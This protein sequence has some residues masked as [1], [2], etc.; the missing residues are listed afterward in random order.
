VRLRSCFAIFSLSLTLLSVSA[1]AAHACVGAQ[2]LQIWSTAPGGGALTLEWDFEVKVQTFESFCTPDRATC[3]YSTIDPGFQAPVDDVAGDSFYRLGDATSVRVELIATAP[4]LTVAINGQ[5]LEDAGDTVNLGTMPDVHVHPSWQILVPGD[6]RGDFDFS[7][8]LITDSP[9][10]QDSDVITVV[11]TNHQ[12]APEPTPTRTPEPSCAGDCNRDEQV[13]VDEILTGVSIA[14]GSISLAECEAFDGNGDEQVSVDELIG[15]IDASLIGCFA[16][17]PVTL[18][19]IQET[20]FTPSCAIETCHNSDSAT[21]N[22]IL[23]AELAR[24]QLISVL[25]DAAPARAAGLLRVAPGNLERSFLYSKLI[26]PRPGHG[27][28]MPLNAPPLPAAQIK[29]VGDWILTGAE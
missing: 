10:Y 26:G 11:V 29:Q 16:V 4:G 7:F 22:L 2:C 13:T 12:P 23:T 28:R 9:A 1:G 19:E 8:R 3:L 18:A 20:I 5:R 15:A 6:Q 25:P 24:E 17:R 14:L 27:S 21:G